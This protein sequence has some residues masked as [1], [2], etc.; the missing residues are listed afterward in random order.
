[1]A[2]IRQRLEQLKRER[3]AVEWS[4][5]FE[6]YLNRVAA[7]PGLTRRSHA[8]IYD[9]IQ[10]AG[11]THGREGAPTYDLFAGEIFGL[12]KAIEEIVRYFY[13][14][15]QSREAAKR[16]LL[17]VGPPGSGKSTIVD[18]LK[19]GLER[20]SHT[21]Q[22]ALYA[23][24]GCPLQEEPLHLAPQELRRE[25][26]EEHG[27]SIDGDL[28]PRCRNILQSYYGGDVALVRVKRITFTR[29]P[30]VGMGS[31][32]PTGSLERD[33]SRLI[34]TALLKDRAGGP[35]D[36][37]QLD[38]ELEAANRGIMELRDIFKC[39]TG[40]L[41]VLRSVAG[42]GAFRLTGDGPL[43][44][45]EVLVAYSTEED[46]RDFSDKDGAGDLL[47]QAVA[48]RVPFSLQASDEA[49]IY[50]RL[51]PVP[52]PTRKSDS[53]DR[54]KISPLA[55]RVA[56]T[57]AVLSRLDRTTRV[58]GL[59]KVS[60]LEKVRLYDGPVIPPYTVESVEK[61][62]R[63]S[64]GEGMGGLSP[65]FVANRLADAMASTKGCLTPLRALEALVEGLMERA[66]KDEESQNRAMALASE[67]FVDYKELAMREVQRASAEEFRAQADQLFDSYVE[68]AELYCAGET[69]ATHPATPLDEKLLRRLESAVRL[70]DVEAHRLREE[71]CRTVRAP[72]LL[73]PDYSSIPV[74]KLAIE[75]ALF[76]SRD[77][78]K[79]R[80][81][82]ETRDPERFYHR[83]RINQRLVEGY[84]YCQE[85][86][87][88]LM[89][90][91]WATL[92]GK[93]AP[94][95]TKGKVTREGKQWTGGTGSAVGL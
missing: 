34:G 36:P 12:D 35:G 4:G 66:G 84:G 81:N 61:L 49:E 15:T 33:I 13:A 89:S 78:L 71:V 93:G 94:K 32:F 16:I 38:G 24:E 40:L 22:G 29:A 58:G 60:L 20:Y 2:D 39:D 67:A 48:V 17:L 63:K 92:S 30:A 87:R 75:N 43:Q 7:D 82:P 52:R 19:D 85:C 88:D 72:G 37:I 8:R 47:D 83:E 14:A 31:F 3:E 76:P 50:S 51:L 79:L 69:S 26:A 25:I 5:T 1:M 70:R 18:L 64:P 46:Y 27:V 41:S 86:A 90:F 6:E 74:L 62:Q 68:N 21:D 65:R 9:M 59:P 44:L 91:V 10:S 23:I 11:V 95:V 54:G 28:C 53:A 42:D 55:L 57:L 45:D 73:A 56:A 77:E 80:L